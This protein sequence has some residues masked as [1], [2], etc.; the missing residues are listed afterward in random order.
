MEPLRVLELYSGIGGM[1][2]AL[3]GER[4]QSTSLLIP[5]LARVIARALGSGGAATSQGRRP[6]DGGLV[7]LETAPA[8]HLLPPLR[9]ETPF[10]PPRALS[11]GRVR[12]LRGL[13]SLSPAL[14]GQAVYKVK[15]KWYPQSGRGEPPDWRQSPV[16]SVAVIYLEAWRRGLL[17]SRKSQWG[18]GGR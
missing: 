12:R 11:E 6:G 15:L 2:Q 9:A 14:R 7:V 4:A 17:L 1:H 13:K 3:R 18:R 10:I 5:A 16:P 8:G